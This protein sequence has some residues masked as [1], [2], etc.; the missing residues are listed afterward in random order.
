MTSD[1]SLDIRVVRFLPAGTAAE[2][3]GM[4]EEVRDQ[5]DAA[6]TLLQNNRMPA[7]AEPLKGR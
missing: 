3:D 5:A 7:D 1:R 4:P 2:Y 6:T